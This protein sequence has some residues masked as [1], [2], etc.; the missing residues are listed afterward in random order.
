MTPFWPCRTACSKNNWADS[1]PLT[2][3]GSTS[4]PRCIMPD[5]WKSSFRDIFACFI[6]FYSLIVLIL[7][8][9]GGDSDYGPTPFPLFNAILWL[10]WLV[11]WLIG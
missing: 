5:S 9:V 10:I 1:A 4:K 11:R 7:I 2:Y 6:I 3:N 8:V